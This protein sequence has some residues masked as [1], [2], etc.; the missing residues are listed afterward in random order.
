MISACAILAVLGRLGLPAEG[1]SAI[2]SGEE[3]ATKADVIW[4]VEY[5]AWRE[6]R[7]INRY[8][9]MLEDAE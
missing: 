1:V 6:G 2:L 7:T 9:K 4:H 8:P 5:T 3:Q